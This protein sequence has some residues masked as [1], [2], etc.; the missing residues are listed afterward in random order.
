MNMCGLMLLKHKLPHPTPHSISSAATY[1]GMEAR[2]VSSMYNTGQE[3]W[4]PKGRWAPLCM[5]Q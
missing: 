3:P 5:P 4:V 1:G 2:G